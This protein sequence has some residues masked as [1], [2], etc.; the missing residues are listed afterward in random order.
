[1]KRLCSSDMDLEQL[2]SALRAQ[3]PALRSDWALLENAG[4]SQVPEEVAD[5]VRDH[6]LKS[7]VQLGAGYP[8]SQQADAAVGGAH[9]LAET[10]ANAEGTG[11]VV[12]G[13]SSTSLIAM[14]AEAYGRTIQPG[15]EI[16]VAENNHEA[17]AGPW[18]RLE[19]Y[20]AIVK[21][22]SVDPETY[23]LTPLEPL[24]SGRTRVVAFPHVSNLLGQVED[25]PG[26]VAAAKAVGADTFV[27]G[28]AY[29]PHRAMDVQAWGVDWYAWSI[30]KV[31]GPHMG[32][33]F[34]THE[35]FAKLDGPGH[36]FFPK[37][38]LAKWEPGG[39]S[40]EGCAGVVAL[41]SY[42]ELAVAERDLSP[43]ALYEKAFGVFEN[44]ERGPG[45]RLVEGLREKGCELIGSHPDADKVATVSFLVPGEAP[46]VT[47]ARLHAAKVAV[48]NG[49]MYSLRLVRSL[50]MEETQGVVRASLVH[51]NSFEEV[52][53]LLEAL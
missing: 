25:V 9:S 38:A 50:G 19:R 12:L 18:Y 22:W 42:L 14:V 52:E 35:A 34:G 5:A 26:F 17:N 8:A 10:M 31:F 7:Y 40:H 33:M 30:Y 36:V 48:R 21:P 24:L 43:R 45:T 20:G 44:L 15:D 13:A 1:M 32:A 41:R 39:V 27:D 28:V 16:V 6:M 46:L 23:A 47:V 51:Y 4:G 29:A 3:F 2:R 37:D 53:R 11:R 49:H